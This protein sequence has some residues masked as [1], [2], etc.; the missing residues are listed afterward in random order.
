MSKDWFIMVTPSLILAIKT[1]DAKVHS[2]DFD[3]SVVETIKRG[4]DR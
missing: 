4:D 3:V 1:A 2:Q